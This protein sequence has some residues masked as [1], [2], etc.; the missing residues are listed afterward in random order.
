MN[1]WCLYKDCFY[2]RIRNASAFWLKRL[3]VL[4]QTPKRF[5]E[6]A[7]AYF[8]FAFTYFSFLYIFGCFY[9]VKSIQ[10]FLGQDSPFLVYFE[11]KQRFFQYIP[12]KYPLYSENIY[13]W[14]NNILIGALH[15][16]KENVSLHRPTGEM[17]GYV[18]SVFCFI[19]NIEI[20]NFK[21]K[22]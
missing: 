15:C 2:V 5:V 13:L 19:L 10:R 17:A 1:C 18:E 14:R 16:Q 7:A 20:A 12:Q 4:I 8:Y 3:N 22:G 9:K 6:Y 11:L 21:Q